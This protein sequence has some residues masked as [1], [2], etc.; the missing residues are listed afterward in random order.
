ME[1]KTPHSQALLRVVNDMISSADTDNNNELDLTQFTEMIKELV[2][3]ADDKELLS[4]DQELVKKLMA[5]F[6]DPNLDPS[7]EMKKEIEEGKKTVNKYENGFIKFL[8][9]PIEEHIPDMKDI[10]FE[11]VE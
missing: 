9:T 7:D 8:D 11:E 10:K 3:T 1:N 2:K 4:N 6:A 5:Y